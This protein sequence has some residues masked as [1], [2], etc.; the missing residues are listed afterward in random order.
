V[1]VQSQ[2]AASPTS[3]AP[4]NKVAVTGLSFGFGTPVR[5]FL[6]HISG[7]PLTST[8]AGYNGSIA[9]TVKIPAKRPAPT[10]RSSPSAPTAARHR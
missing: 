1:V 7:T 9:A 8:V 3:V 4:G 10:T 2:I 5:I 6:D